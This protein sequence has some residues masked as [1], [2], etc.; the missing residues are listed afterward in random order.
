MIGHIK[1]CLET[2][3]S[4]AVLSNTGAGTSVWFY[5]AA[6]S[7]FR[8]TVIVFLTD[9]LFKIRLEQLLEQLDE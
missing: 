8:L 9:D 7:D 1:A 3:G 5:D 2:D 4:K 6:Q